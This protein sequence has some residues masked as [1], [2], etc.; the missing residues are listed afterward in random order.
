[1]ETLTFKTFLLIC[2][3]LQLSRGFKNMCPEGFL[4]GGALKIVW[5]KH[6]QGRKEE[7]G[8][9]RWKA[10]R[11]RGIS[12]GA[13]RGGDWIMLEWKEGRDGR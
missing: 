9:H 1:M 8:R 12:M 6:Y 11:R 5:T 10:S 2:G 13:L 3:N 7:E 4:S